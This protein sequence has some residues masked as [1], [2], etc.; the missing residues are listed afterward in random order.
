MLE[1]I[2]LRIGEAAKPASP[3]VITYATICIKSACTPCTKP[4]MDCTN[5]C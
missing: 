4:S 5:N 3:A 1:D 2:D